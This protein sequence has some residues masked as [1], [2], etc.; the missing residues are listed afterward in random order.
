[1]KKEKEKRLKELD[2][3][4]GYHENYYARCIYSGDLITKEQYDKYWKDKPFDLDDYFADSEIIIKEIKKKKIK[5]DED[6]ERSPLYKEYPQVDIEGTINQKELVVYGFT[7]G[8]TQKEW[9]KHNQELDETVEEV[10]KLYKERDKLE[11]EKYKEETTEKERKE[12]YEEYL[13]DKSNY[14]D[15]RDSYY[16]R[17]MNGGGGINNFRKMYGDGEY[18]SFSEWRKRK[19]Y[20]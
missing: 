7:D 11:E 10:D 16:G 13:E 15:G 4:L 18:F 12:L 8:W 6:W 9:E 1:M 17:S 20:T 14:E 19:N 5:T 2:D 3:I